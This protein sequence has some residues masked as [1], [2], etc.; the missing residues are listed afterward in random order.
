MGAIARAVLKNS[1]ILLCDEATSAL[2]SP[3]EV[4]IMA[5]LKQIAKDR[6]TLLIAHRLT[7][8]QDADQII[9]LNKGHVEESGTHDE[10]LAKRGMYHNM[11]EQQ[12]HAALGID[13]E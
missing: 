5:A 8:V 11:W 9:V 7:T 10:L 4:E 1:P 13:V 2:D 3:T 12:Q 6:T